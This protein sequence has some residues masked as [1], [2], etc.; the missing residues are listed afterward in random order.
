MDFGLLNGIVSGIGTA[1]DIYNNERNYKAQQEAYKTTL[2]RED[3]AIQRRVADLQAAGLSPTLAAGS[4]A[5]SSNYTAPQHAS[6]PKVSAISDM[7]A[8]KQQM[9]NIAQ[10]QADIDRI[11]AQTAAAKATT[12]STELNNAITAYDYKKA[13][14]FGVSTKFLGNQYLE[15]ANFFIDLINRIWPLKDDGNIDIPDYPTGEGGFKITDKTVPDISGVKIPLRGANNPSPL[16]ITGTGADNSKAAD[17]RNNQYYGHWER[18][19]KENGYDTGWHNK[20]VWDNYTTPRGGML[21]PNQRT[22]R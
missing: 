5:S 12:A 8:V 22:T 16:G 14:Q 6:S 18:Y 3:N 19:Y 11:N 7:L 9:Q 13:E 17:R 4:A 15:G 21:K 20:F 1:Y 2:E 10:T